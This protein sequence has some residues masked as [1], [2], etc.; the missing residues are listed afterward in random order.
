MAG[1]I[2]A[3]PIRARTDEGRGAGQD[4]GRQMRTFSFS[5]EIQGALRTLVVRMHRDD[6][7][8]GWWADS[9]DIPGRN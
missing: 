2:R 1:R 5:T 4:A 6:E 3:R 9:D 7:T 8:G